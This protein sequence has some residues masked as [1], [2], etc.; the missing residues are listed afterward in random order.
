MLWHCE[1]AVPKLA[2]K[3]HK[4]DPLLSSLKQQAGLKGGMPQLKLKRTA[5]F[6]AIKCYQ[7]TKIIEVTKL[8]CGMV[9][10]WVCHFVTPITP[11]QGYSLILVY[12]RRVLTTRQDRT[13]S[14]NN[15]TNSIT[16]VVEPL[17]TPA[18]WI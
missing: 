11:S 3:R 16:M 6:L 9:Q 15:M 12:I 4:T 10:A 5:I 8:E 13:K 7:W 1:I 18:A 14:T 17:A 2:F